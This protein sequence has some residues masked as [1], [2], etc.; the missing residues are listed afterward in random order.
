VRAAPSIRTNSGGFDI[1]PPAV[2]PDADGM[3]T[4]ML[5]EIIARVEAMD[6]AAVRDVADAWSAIGTDLAASITTLGNQ[7]LKTIQTAWSGPAA[8]M[9]VS[10]VM[11]YTTHCRLLAGAATLVGA[12]VQAAQS[13]VQETYSRLRT[14]PAGVEPQEHDGLP[15]LGRYQLA[16]HEQQVNQAYAQQIL[17]QV[18]RPAIHAGDSGV[19]V[20]PSGPDVLRLNIAAAR[21]PAARAPAAAPPS[22]AGERPG[23]SEASAGYGE[24]SYVDEWWGTEQD[25]NVL[26]AGFALGA[27]ISPHQGG[28]EDNASAPGDDHPPRLPREVEQR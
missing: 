22:A 19:P 15:R 17:T 5:S 20:L 3:D 27:P 1:E 7:L 8:S 14:L 10:A 24:D 26:P 25:R 21:T 11:A 6:P 2:G 13:G 18:Y 9:A 16:C 28:G 23:E 4:M 12:R